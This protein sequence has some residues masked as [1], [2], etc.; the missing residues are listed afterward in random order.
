VIGLTTSTNASRVLKAEMD[1]AGAELAE[2]YNIAQFVGKIEGS[3][4]LRWPVP[5]HEG[6]VIVIDEATQASTADFALVQ[7]AARYAGAFLHPIGDTAQLGA[8]EA[9]G[10]FHLLVEDLGGPELTEILRSRSQRERD[11]SLRIRAGQVQAIDVYNRRGRIRGADT[12]AVMVDAATSY[13]S[14]LLRARNVLG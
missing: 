7:Q 14:D 13:L 11:A 9:G 3:S 6:D 1:D 12:D 10:I 2:S 4:E 5:V 8:V